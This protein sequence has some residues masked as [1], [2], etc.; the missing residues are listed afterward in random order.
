MRLKNE[1]VSAIEHACSDLVGLTC[2]AF[3]AG[4]SA[5]SQVTFHLGSKRRRRYPID[6]KLLSPD[7][8]IYEGEWMIYVQCCAWRL[9]EKLRT[10]CS[11]KSD[12]RAGKEMLVG[13]RRLIGSKVEI[14]QLNATGMDLTLKFAKHQSLSL[15]PDCMD[16]KLDGNNYSIFSPKAIITVGPGGNLSFDQRL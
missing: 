9:D 16:R 4:A 1:S 5:G 10:I 8:R 13:L 3:I 14:S 7:L 15:F 12:N 6:N 11:S 2:W